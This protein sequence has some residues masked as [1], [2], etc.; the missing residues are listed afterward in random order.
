MMR[1]DAGVM[2]RKVVLGREI[3]ENHSNH[4]GI[5]NS[6]HFVTVVLL[7]TCVKERVEVVKHVQYLHQNNM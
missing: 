5:T 6:L 1:K 4:V 2:E 7:N 3:N